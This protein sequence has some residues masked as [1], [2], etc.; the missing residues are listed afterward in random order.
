MS[1]IARL[2]SIILGLEPK[3]RVE[4]YRE[5]VILRSGIAPMRL[6]F[7][8]DCGTQHEPYLRNH[9]ARLL[10][11]ES[12][13]YIQSLFHARRHQGTSGLSDIPLPQ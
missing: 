11:A 6:R 8:P 9:W 4:Y 3:A 2:A 7:V 12:A 10:E 5:I 1:V 13:I